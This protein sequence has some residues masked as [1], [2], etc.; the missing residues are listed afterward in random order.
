MIKEVLFDL[1]SE[2]ICSNKLSVLY[3][4]NEHS[5]V[6]LVMPFK[7]GYMKVIYVILRGTLQS[8]NIKIFV[9]MVTNHNMNLV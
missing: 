2:C 5:L 6:K 4:L 1:K 8:S 7:M 9:I 3:I